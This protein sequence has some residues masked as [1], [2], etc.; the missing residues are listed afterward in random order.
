L[1]VKSLRLAL[2]TYH[3]ILGVSASLGLFTKSFN[4][5]FYFKDGLLKSEGPMCF[6]S[7]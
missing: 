6:F 2:D 4:D 7:C 1:F 3:V 5:K